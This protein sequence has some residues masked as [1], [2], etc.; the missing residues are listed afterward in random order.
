MN[1]VVIIN[2]IFT[3]INVLF[4]LFIFHFVFFGISGLVHKKKYPVAEELCKYAVVVSCKDEEKVIGRLIK[5]IKSSDY[6]QD[7]LDIYVIVHNC[8][9]N[10]A[11]VAKSIG[12][13]VIIYNDSSKNRVGYAYNYAFKNIDV[14]GYEGVIF[15]DADNVVAKDYFLKLNNAFVYY[16]KKAVVTTFRHAL[17]MDK[18]VLPATYGI[19]FATCCLLGFSGRDN[20]NVSSRIT[21]CGFVMPASDLKDGWNYFGLTQDVEFSADLV[22]KGKTIHYCNEATFYDEQP[23]NFLVMWRQ[24]LRWAAGQ[25]EAKKKYMFKS[26]KSFFSKEHK[27]K[28]SLHVLISFLSTPCL[29]SLGI[30]ALGVLCLLFSPLANVSLYDAFLFWDNSASWI[31]NMFLSFKTGALFV[32][33]RNMIVLYAGAF[34]TGIVVLLVGHDKYQKNNKFILA[35]SLLFY[36]LFLLLQFPLDL[37]ALFKHNVAWSKIPHGE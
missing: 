10:T 14:S 12:A 1:Y 15:F 18:G 29:L 4:G 13:N 9:D 20:F 30:F 28:I 7:K 32:L 21:G 36:P 6:P 24:R 2:I 33:L 34:I 17:N 31:S 16:E 26:I 37:A 19:Y 23:R 22:N 5:S 11:S 3:I 35:V 25:R 27:N 8:T